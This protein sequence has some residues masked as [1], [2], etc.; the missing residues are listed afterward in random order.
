MVYV[1]IDF[2]V[3][4][5][6]SGAWADKQTQSQMNA[7][8]THATCQLGQQAITGISITVPEKRC[9]IPSLRSQLMDQER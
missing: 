1:C 2:D 3:N 5:S 4:S 6:Y 7:P 9:V 8:F